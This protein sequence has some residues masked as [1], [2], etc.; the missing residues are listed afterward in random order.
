MLKRGLASLGMCLL[1]AIHQGRASLRPER[2]PQP[3]PGASASRSDERRPGTRDQLELSPEGATQSSRNAFAAKADRSQATCGKHAIE[4]GPEF[5][6]MHWA[7]KTKDGRAFDNGR[8]VVDA[9]GESLGSEI[10]EPSEVEL[11]GEG[12]WRHHV[13]GDQVGLKRRDQTNQRDASDH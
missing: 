6:V 4:D 3:E 12:E 1:S 9:D 8:V 7:G 13:R 2:P 5:G 10:D 11:G